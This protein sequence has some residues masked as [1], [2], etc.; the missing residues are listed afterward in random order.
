MGFELHLDNWTNAD[1]LALA[2][3]SIAIKSTRGLAKYE[4]YILED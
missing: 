2:L 1:I 4:D 3:F